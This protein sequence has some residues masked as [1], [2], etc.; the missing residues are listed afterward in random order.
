MFEY[1]K[2]KGIFYYTLK[3]QIEEHV[4]HRNVWLRRFVTFYHV[5]ISL[6]YIHAIICMF[7]NKQNILEYDIMFLII[8]RYICIDKYILVCFFMLDLFIICINFMMRHIN[9][10]QNGKYMYELV[11]L[12]VED[13]TANNPTLLPF[14]L[15]PLQFYWQKIKSKLNKNS[16]FKPIQLKNSF[17]HFALMSHESRIKLLKFLSACES[18]TGMLKAI[19]G[20]FSFIW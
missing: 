15:W 7:T 17:K 13:F 11:V 4:P 2:P 19:F 6:R 3:C 8:A 20:L 5:S 10:S 16:D 18:L 12:N 14:Q 9:R 1:F